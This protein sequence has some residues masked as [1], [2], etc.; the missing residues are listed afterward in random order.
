[1]PVYVCVVTTSTSG[2]FFE[3]SANSPRRCT[4]SAK[5]DLRSLNLEVGNVEPQDVQG[6]SRAHPARLTR[7]VSSSSR[8]APF[9]RS[10]PVVGA[11][12]P[13]RI[14][15][16]SS[17]RFSVGGARSAARRHG[18]VVLRAR[19]RGQEA[20]GRV[21]ISS[22][23]SALLGARSTARSAPRRCAKVLSARVGGQ[24]RGGARSTAQ[25]DV[26]RV[27][28]WVMVRWPPSLQPG[29]EATCSSARVGVGES[30]VACR[31]TARR[32]SGVF[33]GAS[34]WAKARWHDGP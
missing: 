27:S 7:M 29:V 31:P 3:I 25:R 14:F 21:A 17:A 6:W 19:R 32:H 34:A 2:L 30:A 15:E 20:R 24:G 9:E 8:E 1:M 5:P 4:T 10:K 22:A 13:G 18:E 26:R 23:Q 28:A 12:D 11:A 16:A 33:L